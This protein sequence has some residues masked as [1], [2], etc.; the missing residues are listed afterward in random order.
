ML[1]PSWA[2]CLEIW[3]PQNPGTVIAVIGLYKDC[4][5][6]ISPKRS[7]SFRAVVLNIGHMVPEMATTSFQ[8]ATV[9]LEWATE[10]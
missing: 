8:L 3:Y 10:T 1:P 9:T 6:L 5:N 7:S 2:D 4:F